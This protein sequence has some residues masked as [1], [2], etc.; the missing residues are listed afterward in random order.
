MHVVHVF[1]YVFTA[2]Q[3]DAILQIVNESPT[4]KD[5]SCSCQLRCA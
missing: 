5:A 2:S 1:V 3:S 4:S